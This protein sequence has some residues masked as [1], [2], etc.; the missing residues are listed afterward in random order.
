MET[1]FYEFSQNNSGGSFITD[2]NLCHRL[3][4]EATTYEG[5]IKKAKEMGVYFD[6][7]ETGQD[8]SCCGDRWYEPNDK[9]FP[10]TYGSFTEEEALKYGKAYNAKIAPSKSKNQYG[11]R[12]YDVIFETP[13]SYMQYVAD[14]YGWTNPDGRIFYLD[15]NIKEIESHKDKAK[16]IRGY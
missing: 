2:N 15:G 9:K 13:E 11:N 8:C 4:I 16:V 3:L 7:C 12:K 5:A 14:F 6:G 10:L 1:R